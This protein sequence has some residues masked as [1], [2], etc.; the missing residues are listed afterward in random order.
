M[1]N[2]WLYGT[3]VSLSPLRQEAPFSVGFFW[4][5]HVDDNALHVVENKITEPVSAK[6]FLYRMP[7]VR[8]AGKLFLNT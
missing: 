6:Y 8:Q 7:F 2:I 5:L 1:L 4:L 3:I